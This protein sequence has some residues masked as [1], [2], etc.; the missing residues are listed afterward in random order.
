MKLKSSRASRL[1]KTLS[2]ELRV[3][4]VALNPGTTI[5]IVRSS[6]SLSCVKKVLQPQTR[7]NRRFLFAA[8]KRPYSHNSI[9]KQKEIFDRLATPARSSST[10]VYS[11][12]VTTVNAS[13]SNQRQFFE[14]LFNN[15]TLNFCQINVHFPTGKWLCHIITMFISIIIVNL[16]RSSS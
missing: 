8:G 12:M 16:S 9:Q 5:D 4:F 14:S 13:T 11:N 7:G 2:K 3:L 1:L 10:A 6:G 15:N